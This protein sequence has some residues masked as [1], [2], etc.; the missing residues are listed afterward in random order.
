VTFSELISFITIKGETA[1]TIKKLLLLLTAARASVEL[2][3]AICGFVKKSKHNDS[4]IKNEVRLLK[5][6]ITYCHRLTGKKHGNFCIRSFKVS[7]SKSH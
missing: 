4:K 1:C 6:D 3:E 2:E 5:K 7:F